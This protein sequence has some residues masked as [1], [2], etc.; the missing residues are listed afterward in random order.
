LLRTLAQAEYSTH[1]LGHFALASGAY[2]HFT[3]PIR[4]YP[5]LVTHRALKAF[6]KRKRGEAGP[7]PVPKMPALR[8]ATHW[9]TVSSARERATV[10]AE[11]DAKALF[12]A[13]H[14]RDRIGD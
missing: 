7:A 11:R 8:D 5:D 14:M 4:R 9:A 2:V 10:Q 3:S 12:A 13:M 6:I 1:N